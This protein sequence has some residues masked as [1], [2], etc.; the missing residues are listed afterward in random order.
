MSQLLLFE[1]V[2]VGVGQAAVKYNPNPA[3][4]I[5]IPVPPESRVA[6]RAVWSYAG[7]YSKHEW[8]VGRGATSVYARLAD[9]RARS[10]DRI[11]I[12]VEGGTL[13]AINKGEWGGTVLF[14]PTG[15]KKETVVSR[16]QVVAFVRLP[17]GLYAVEGLAHLSMSRGSI[18]RLERTKG[19]AGWKTARVVKLPAA[20]YAATIRRDGTLI[21][22][23][24][25]GVVAYEAKFGT[26]RI[27]KA[28]AF[29]QFYPSSSALTPDERILYV[30]MR[31]YVAQ[32]ELGTGQVRMLAPSRAF[33]NKLSPNE[34]R[35]VRRTYGGSG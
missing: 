9:N 7:N 28:S 4:W 19:G 3:Q 13:M 21:I 2:V 27:V 20:P 15:S 26:Q 5:E 17:D 11:S 6:D 8:I 34:E 1:F 25:D 12:A 32:V 30:G 24:S 35:S 22:T 14:R 33:L 23:L 18:L 29:S 31:Q 16:D 10:K